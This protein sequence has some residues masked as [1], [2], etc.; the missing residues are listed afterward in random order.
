MPAFEFGQRIAERLEE[1]FVGIEKHAVHA[2]LDHRLR[3]AD[4]I[5]LS[6]EISGFQLWALT[7]EANFTTLNGLPV[8]SR[9]GL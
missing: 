7:S 9:I 8:S 5:D 4:G 3:L 2:E 1:V 6:G